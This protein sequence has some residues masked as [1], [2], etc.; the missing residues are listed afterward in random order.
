[1]PVRLDGGRKGEGD[2]I[3]QRPAGCEAHLRGRLSAIYDFPEHLSLRS[4]L[5]QDLLGH[6][7]GATLQTSAR[8]EFRISDRTEISIGA[9]FTLADATYMR[10]FMGVP[11]GVAGVTTALL[12]YH[13]AG[14]CTVPMWGWKSRP[15]WPTAG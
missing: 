12:A 5:N 4:T 3:P 6:G 2:A 10:S 9:G 7:G 13:L 14:A 1:M 11:A 15:P 8:Y